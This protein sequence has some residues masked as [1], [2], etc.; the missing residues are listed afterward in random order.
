[1]VISQKQV[2]IFN[3]KKEGADVDFLKNPNYS[4]PF[5]S[6]LVEQSLE[7]MEN[8]CQ[9]RPDMEKEMCKADEAAC[10]INCKEKIDEAELQKLLK[11]VEV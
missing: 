4:S 7:M 3:L 2:K 6:I 5:C 11:E 9:L 8:L 10:L 1:M